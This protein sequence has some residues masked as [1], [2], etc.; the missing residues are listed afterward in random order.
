[1]RLR[2]LSH[3]VIKKVTVKCRKMY[4][5][6]SGINF[7]GVCEFYRF[8]PCIILFS[9]FISAFSFCLILCLCFCILVKEPPNVCPAA[10]PAPPPNSSQFPQSSRRDR[11]QGCTLAAGSWESCPCHGGQAWAP[12]RGGP[13]DPK[14]IWAVPRTW[15]GMCPVPSTWRSSGPWPSA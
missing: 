7:S 2:I 5:D 6:V 9:R 1:M 8:C 11:D 4:R 14:Q 10:L 3:E 12:V 13:W 15:T